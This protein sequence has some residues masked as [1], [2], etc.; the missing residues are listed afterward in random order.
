[1][2]IFLIFLYLFGYIATGWAA[3]QTTAQHDTPFSFNVAAIDSTHI[4]F[5]WQVAEDHYLYRDKLRIQSHT[6]EINLGYVD[7]P[8]GQ[9]RND[10]VFGQV[11]VYQQAGYVDIPVVNTLTTDQA[12]AFTISYQ[13]CPDIGQC[14]PMQYADVAIQMPSHS[15]AANISRAG[16]T[17]FLDPEVAFIFNAKVNEIGQLLVTWHIAEHYYLYKNK[18]KFSTSSGV[19]AAAQFPEAVIKN[20]VAY[21]ETPVYYNELTI[22]LPWVNYPS[23]ND[24]NLTVTYQGCANAGL[25]YPPQD[26]S[27]TLTLPSQPVQTVQNEILKPATT[28]LSS[29]LQAWQNNSLDIP[30]SATQSS[31]LLNFDT[32]ATTQNSSALPSNTDF[33]DPEVAF[34]LSARSPDKNTVIAQWQI[35]PAYYLYRDKFTFTANTGEKITV[36]YPKGKLKQDPAFGEVEVY[37]QAILTIPLTLDSSASDVVITVGYQG[38]A[39]AGLCYPPMDKALAITLG[40][41]QVVIAAPVEDFVENAPTISTP[42]KQTGLKNA[43][44]LS[45][46]DKIAFAL[47]N[48]NIF[49]TLM[50]LFGLGVLLSFTP[51]VFPMIPILSSIIIGQKENIT[52][53]RA[54]IV[55]LVYVLAMSVTYTIAGVFTGLL[56]ENLQAVFQTPWMLISFSLV[57][58]ALAF[59]M[60][61]FYELQLPVSLQNKLM[62]LSNRQEGGTLVGVAIMGLLS[63]LIVGPCVA[64]PLAGILIY[65]GQTGDAL[66]GG[67][68]LFFLSLGM[69]LPLLLIGVS[70]GRFLPKAGEW[71]EAVKSVFGVLMLALAIWMLERILSAQITLLLWASFLIICSIYMG[72][73][74]HL[75]AGVSGWRRLWKGLGLVMLIY[76][77]ILM[78]G[79]ASGHQ[80]I[81]QP[82]EKFTQRQTIGTS[83]AASAHEKFQQIKG[84]AGLE[85]ALQQAK[86]TGKMVMFDFYA[87]WCISCK[88]METLTFSHPDVMALFEKIQLVQADVTANDAEDKALYKK[89]GIF[90]PPAILFFD[91]TGKELKEYR[92]IGFMPADKF[93]KHLTQVLAQ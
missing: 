21:G 44:P 32:K 54:F 47:A 59:S 53:H 49:Y 84:I 34:T 1:M 41:N 16:D 81:F 60:F 76:G 83:T 12:T 48:N 6:P 90:G 78:F 62:E 4:R 77:I 52:T 27:V 40:D 58:V 2:R 68:A 74:D 17:D 56:G 50:A 67:T 15:K 72:V 43:P 11:A 71:M 69:G 18:I 42:A 91:G 38:C 51:C 37:E 70:A 36:N 85:T 19:L 22:T 82:L 25:C 64:A 20:D 33:L 89:F 86:T 30:S 3:P 10:S 5:T 57:F 35:T 65:I 80:S 39:D 28:D 88:E 26:K 87:D 73:L 29:A 7:L 8:I 14:A 93:S 79:A 75:H 66:F 46:Q 13:G 9:V 23:T 45:E 61:G 92:V 24:I 31:G 55:S 63:A